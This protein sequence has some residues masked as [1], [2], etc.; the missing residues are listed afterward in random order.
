MVVRV[1]KIEPTVFVLKKEE[2]EEEEKRFTLCVVAVS[3]TQTR[4]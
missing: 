4:Q 2:E 1:R 3:W